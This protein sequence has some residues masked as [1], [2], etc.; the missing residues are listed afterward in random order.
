[1]DITNKG[2][3]LAV[4]KTFEAFDARGW[5]KHG[6]NERFITLYV[7]GHHGA[8]QHDLSLAEVVELQELLQRAVTQ[9][10]EE[11]KNPGSWDIEPF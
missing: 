8:V 4:K 5:R 1:M 10:G 3:T 6:N 7:Q 9:S 2:D 11:P